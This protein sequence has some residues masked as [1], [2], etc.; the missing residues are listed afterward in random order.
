MKPYQYAIL[1]YVN[2]LSSGEFVNIGLLMWLPNDCK[3]IYRINHRYRRVSEFFY[4]FDS[5]GYQQMMYRVKQRCLQIQKEV[6]ED[7]YNLFIKKPTHILEILDRIIT[8]DSTCFQWSEISSGGVINPA[9][10]FEQ[11]ALEFVERHEKHTDRERQTESKILQNVEARIEAC[12]LTRYLKENMPIV[13]RN[14]SYTFRLGWNNHVTQVLEPI[15]FDYVNASDV[16]EKAITWSGR[17]AN[18]ANSEEFQMTGVIAPPA[19]NTWLNEYKRAI[20]I[21]KEAPKIRE[22]ITETDF[23]DF[24]PKI[25]RDMEIE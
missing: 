11:L 24:I 6:N 7:N 19:N 4:P 17:L 20:E 21:L 16:V 3:M 9:S 22:L 13:S 5:S 14:Y 23:D 18:L 12:G 15:T 2:N 25:K 10:R 1:R 8:E